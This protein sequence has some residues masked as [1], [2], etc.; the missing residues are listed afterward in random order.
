ME[1]VFLT[2]G[3][4]SRYRSAGG[5]RSHFLCKVS[6]FVLPSAIA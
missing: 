4:G 5:F 3:L 6:F 1:N 2:K